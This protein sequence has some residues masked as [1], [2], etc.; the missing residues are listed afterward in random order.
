MNS[1][2]P[3]PTLKKQKTAAKKRYLKN[4]KIRRKA[5]QASAPKKK[6]RLDTAK[7]DDKNGD[8][9][10]SDSSNSSSSSSNSSSE[11]D[12]D[13]S[14]DSDDEK[15]TTK[16]SKAT[17]KEPEALKKSSSPTEP[18]GPVEA[19]QLPLLAF[20]EPQNL[21]TATQEEL[22]KLGLPDVF[23]NEIP[24]DANQTFPSAQSHTLGIGQRLKSRL[25]DIGFESLFAVQLAAIPLLIGD[26][27]ENIRHPLYP[28]ES[29]RDICVSAPTGSGKTLGYTLPIV[30]IISRRLVTRLRALVVLPTRDLVSQVKETF[31]IFAKG[32]D[33]K[34]GTITGQQ[35]FQQEQAKLVDQTDSVLAGGCSKVD[36][37]IATPGRLIDHINSTPNFTLQH[38]R[39]LV[40]DEADRL[41]NQSFQSWIDRIQVALTT[42]IQTQPKTD[43]H[44]ALGYPNSML[45]DEKHDLIETFERPQRGVQKMLFSATLTTDP[46]KIRSLHLNEPKFVIV[47]NNKVEDYAIPTTLEERMIVSETAYKPLI[48]FKEEV[49]NGP[50]VAS[51]SSDLSPQERQKMLTKFRDGEVDMLI[52]TDVIA[53][54]IDIQGI[55]N[56]INYDIPLDMPK[57]VHRVGRTARA[58]LVGKAWTL[59]EVQEAKYF[60]TYTKN[61]KHEVKKARPMT[62]E[63]EPLME[64]YDKAWIETTM[65]FDFSNYNIEE[66]TQPVAVY[67]DDY[68]SL[69]ISPTGGQVRRVEDDI[70]KTEQPEVDPEQRTH[71]FTVDQPTPVT[72]T[73]GYFG[74]PFVNLSNANRHSVSVVAP[75]DTFIKPATVIPPPSTSSSIPGHKLEKQQE[76]ELRIIDEQEKRLK[77]SLKNFLNSPHR[78]DFGE[79]IISISTPQTAQKSYGNEKR[80]IAP[81]PQ[82]CLIGKNWNSENKKGGQ[83]HALA[84]D[85]GQLSPSVQVKLGNGLQAHDCELKWSQFTESQS[86]QSNLP[87]TPPDSSPNSNKSDYVEES[88]DT[89]QMTMLGKALA[90]HLHITDV[91]DDRKITNC[92][93]EFRITKYEYHFKGFKAKETKTQRRNLRISWQLVTGTPS[94]W[95]TGSDNC[96]NNENGINLQNATFTPDANYWDPFII[97]IYDTE[98]AGDTLPSVPDDWPTPPVG[99]IA[100]G[101]NSTAIKANCVVVLQSLSHGVVSP[102]LIVRRGGKGTSVTGG[103]N[104]D[105]YRRR[106]SLD[107][108]SHSNQR[109]TGC[110]KGSVLGE[111]TVQ[112]NKVGLELAV[113][114]STEPG[115]L[116]ASG[117]YLTCVDELIR[118][119]V[120]PKS[121]SGAVDFPVK[122]RDNAN[123]SR[124]TSYQSDIA[125][126]D[127][128]DISYRPKR[129]SSARSSTDQSSSSRNKRRS[130]QY[131]ANNLD[132]YA[133]NGMTW[134]LDVGEIALWTIS[135]VEV[136]NHYI[137]TPEFNASTIDQYFK[138]SNLNVTVPIPF[139]STWIKV[140]SKANGY[141]PGRSNLKF[142]NNMDNVMQVFGKNFQGFDNDSIDLYF[143]GKVQKKTGVGLGIDL[144]GEYKPIDEE[145]E[146]VIWK[147][148]FVDYISNDEIIVGLPSNEDNYKVID[149]KLN[150]IAVIKENGTI[151][152]T[153]LQV[154]EA[155][156][157]PKNSPNLDTIGSPP[158]RNNNSNQNEQTVDD[159]AD[160]EQIYK[161]KGLKDAAQRAIE[162]YKR[163]EVKKVVVR[164]KAIG[165]APIMKQ[166]YYKISESNKFYT[167]IQ[168]LRK[169][170]GLSNSNCPIFCYI[171]SAFAPTPDDTIGNLYKCYGTEG[172]LIVNYSTSVAWG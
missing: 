140:D 38:L 29:P 88:N 152:P 87:L 95:P 155:L 138:R 146:I 104:V 154:Q 5:N 70:V 171:N 49:G 170:C 126:D 125:N 165:A 136:H 149:D 113:Q 25:T 23:A 74:H 66:S 162:V 121:Q 166:N 13:D 128:Q 124:R 160:I 167:V 82:V 4:K 127:S 55:E 47:R 18:P 106:S 58:G 57:Y 31:E 85:L 116:E 41:L 11:S 139:F 42:P 16:E 96:P 134:S 33:L 168:F 69:S 153:N 30:E 119:I 12:S 163:K 147:S 22:K 94:I 169:E 44:D 123:K 14:S 102:P 80:F 91:A 159:V 78:V 99:A 89:N 24:V 15:V 28:S 117:M 48:L 92:Y 46:S 141:Q 50:T 143:Y 83:S 8:K 84:L 54:G 90:R 118:L 75:S 98:H 35:S 52:S 130:S 17:T 105:D 157:S 64:A 158:A 6:R 62:K 73:S 72:P 60:K 135:G 131:D 1:A 68:D 148:T 43:T 114:S 34:I 164:F 122:D 137:Y 145:E 112:L 53:R 151:I 108:N 133:E 9:E 132:A 101:V 36:I 107:S 2:A 71:T 111:S 63:V 115:Q 10:S 93:A 109:Q 156:F 76:D 65:D 150:L 81:P 67:Q 26:L 51:F 110:I 20:P 59:V 37:L 40:I 32:T 172:H 103:G 97:W 45:I 161:D 100:S 3:A 129:K 21:N 79:Q 56:V 120:P 86:K 19:P 144:G 77:I 61:A 142:Y 27:K 7:T 39:F